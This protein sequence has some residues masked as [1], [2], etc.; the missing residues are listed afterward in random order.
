MYNFRS[1]S[2]KCPTIF[3]KF[4]FSHFT[5]QV[6]LFF[7]EKRKPKI[8]GFKNVME[9]QIRKNSHFR[10]TLNCIWYFRDN[11]TKTLVISERF[12]F[13][14]D[15]RTDTN[16]ITPLSIHFY[17]SKSTRDSLKSV[18]NVFRR[19]PLLGAP[20]GFQRTLLASIWGRHWHSYNY[21][22]LLNNLANNDFPATSGIMSQV[23][24]Q[25]NSS[26]FYLLMRPISRAPHK[27]TSLYTR[28]ISRQ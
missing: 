14:L 9:K 19:K 6:G 28:I 16:F 2:N 8:C 4:T 12:K 25:N 7:A 24:T 10:N 27:P 21:V 20:V 11:K 3:S 22:M 18:F 15:D 5:P 26:C 13:P 23:Q 17:G 1:E